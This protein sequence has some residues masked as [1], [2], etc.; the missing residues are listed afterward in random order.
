MVTRSKSP[1][2]RLGTSLSM[3]TGSAAKALPILWEGIRT[4]GADAEELRV[5][6]DPRGG[7]RIRVSLAG[8]A[9]ENLRRFASS[10]WWSGLCNDTAGDERRALIRVR[11]EN[12]HACMREVFESL[13]VAGIEIE[14]IEIRRRHI[15]ADLPSIVEGEGMLR[16]GDADLPFICALSEHCELYEIGGVRVAIDP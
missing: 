4:H 2:S 9:P 5:E 8:D 13:A 3:R 11:G 16:Y 1:S 15:A 10:R 14:W 7:Q 12:R 6:Q